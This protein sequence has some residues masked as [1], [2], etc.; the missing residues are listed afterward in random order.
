MASLPNLCPTATLRSIDD[1]RGASSDEVVISFRAEM[2][3]ENEDVLQR[4]YSRYIR[5][6][7]T[8]ARTKSFKLSTEFYLTHPE[9]CWLHIERGLEPLFYNDSSPLGPLRLRSITKEDLTDS[10]S[11]R[12]HLP[13]SLKY[14]NLLL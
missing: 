12:A 9:I 6:T 14:R 10:S 4:P 2:L 8:M 13:T 7:S 5:I 1:T 3:S 11:W